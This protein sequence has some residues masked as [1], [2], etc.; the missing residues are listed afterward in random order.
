M[1]IS[2]VAS[3]IQEMNNINVELNRLTK[4][5]SDLAKKKKDIKQ[6]IYNYLKENGEQGV[7]CGESIVTIDT[8]DSRVRK[9]KKEREE[10]IQSVLK[11]CGIKNPKEVMKELDTAMKGDLVGVEQ[12]IIKKVK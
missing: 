1:S 8:K 12:V 5:K 10:Q 9:K 7:R 4:V 3:L 2:H 11:K 6:S